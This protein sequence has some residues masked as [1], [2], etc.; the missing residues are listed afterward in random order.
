MHLSRLKLVKNLHVSKLL[1]VALYVSGDENLFGHFFNEFYENIFYMKVCNATYRTV[2][3]IFLGDPTDNCVS[4]GDLW[5]F[6][7]LR[8]DAH[9]LNMSRLGHLSLNISENSAA[10]PLPAKSLC[11]VSCKIVH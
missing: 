11:S 6:Y 7:L 3:G 9:N 1:K 2:I 8:A 5:I 10:E 4:Y